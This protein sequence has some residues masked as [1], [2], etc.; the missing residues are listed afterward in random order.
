MKRIYYLLPILFLIYSCDNTMNTL[1]PETGI[2]EVN[3]TKLHYELTGAGECIVFIH[4]NFGDCR[5][6]DYQF[7]HFAKKYKVLRY[8][9]RGYGKS[10]MPVKGEQ[11]APHD[12]LKAL[13]DYLEIEKAHFVGFSMGS[14]IAIDFA[15]E[16][17]EMAYSLTVAG[18]T[19]HGNWSPVAQDFI[20]EYRS[21]SSIVKEKGIKGAAEEFIEFKSLNSH[22]MSPE[23][24]K[25]I[26]EIAYDYSF[27]HFL[28]PE[29]IKIAPDAVNLFDNIK[30]PTLIITSEYDIKYCREVADLLNEKIPQSLKVDIDDATHY[31]F[32]DKPNEFNSS[33]SKFL[34]DL[35]Y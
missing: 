35:N 24:K 10:A 6:W 11:Y 8:D 20:R 25:R 18:P 16:Y 3:G 1:H 27:W 12:D 15:V 9:V 13:L 5:H 28:N 7:E 4:G 21:V 31:M 34:V 32:M 23:V 14:G 33:L 17:P 2:A 29:K 22:K 30:F 26:I 19:V